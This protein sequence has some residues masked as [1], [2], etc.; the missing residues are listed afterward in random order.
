MRSY[1]A[2]L[3]GIL[4]RAQSTQKAVLSNKYIPKT[5]VPFGFSSRG[6]LGKKSREEADPGGTLRRTYRNEPTGARLF[7]RGGLTGQALDPSQALTPGP[8]VSPEDLDALRRYL[9]AWRVKTTEEPLRSEVNPWSGR[10][11][12]PSPG[13]HGGRAM[14]MH[15]VTHAL[16][17]V[18]PA[19]AR[20]EMEIPAMVAET[21]AAGNA[22]S[23]NP[24][25]EGAY[26]DK[27]G[28]Q[29][30]GTTKDVEETDRWISALRGKGKTA[31][32][33]T[34]AGM[35]KQYMDY[36]FNRSS[37]DANKEAQVRGKEE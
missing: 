13:L 32:E 34:L 35:Y 28:P 30:T 22:A 1:T 37:R 27:H 10:I 17:R 3:W 4:K 12:V 26:I 36:W 14:F 15:E 18:H 31:S 6:A 11:T 20:W 7:R 9:P 21:K 24:G 19:R 5:D 33:D 2:V 25:W 8:N 16:D 29:Y 23:L